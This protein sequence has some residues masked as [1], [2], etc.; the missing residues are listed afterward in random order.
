VIVIVVVGVDGGAHGDKDKENVV[1][2]RE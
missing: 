1:V 2:R